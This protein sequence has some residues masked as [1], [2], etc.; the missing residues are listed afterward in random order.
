M[1]LTVQAGYRE[2]QCLRSAYSLGSSGAASAYGRRARRRTGCFRD[3]S[4]VRYSHRVPIAVTEGYAATVVH[5]AENF[6][7]YEVHDTTGEIMLAGYAFSV[8]DA[9]ETI[10]DQL[11]MFA[12]HTGAAKVTLIP[13][14]GDA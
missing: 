13:S 8:D 6:V 5:L 4:A 11:A 14:E 1:G 10:L 2:V 3:A 12:G 7:R 9:H